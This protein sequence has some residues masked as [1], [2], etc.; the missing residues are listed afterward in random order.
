MF[1]S[2]ITLEHSNGDFESLIA[3]L[4]NINLNGLDFIQDSENKHFTAEIL[5][6]YDE[7][8]EVENMV[9]AIKKMVEE[10]HGR[11]ILYTVERKRIS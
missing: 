5:H 9:E 2:K 1:L 6:H 10:R 3:L 8:E 4:A 11:S 7:R